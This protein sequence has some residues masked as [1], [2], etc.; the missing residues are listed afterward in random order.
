[1]PLVRKDVDTHEL[2]LE[3]SYE[4][5]SIVMNKIFIEILAPMTD[6]YTRIHQP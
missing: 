3:W 1:M 5:N 6:A 2:Q 4:E